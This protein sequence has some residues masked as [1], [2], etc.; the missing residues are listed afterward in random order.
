MDRSPRGRGPGAD[1]GE[2]WVG[3]DTEERTLGMEAGIDD[4]LSHHQRLLHRPGDRRPHPHLREGEPQAVCVGLD[5]E[6]R[7][8]P[9]PSDTEVVEPEDRDAG[10][11]HQV[12]RFGCLRTASGNRANSSRVAWRSRGCPATSGNPGHPGGSWMGLT[13]SGLGLRATA[14]A[15]SCVELAGTAPGGDPAPLRWSVHPT[16]ASPASCTCEGFVIARHRGACPSS[17]RTRGWPPSVP[18]SAESRSAEPD[19]PRRTRMWSSSTVSATVPCSP[20]A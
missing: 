6:G 14:A 8:A 11:A 5:P 7:G 12:P 2:P 19:R 18:P 16:T 20:R 4:Y 3:V 17:R 9:L 15:T 10:G 1:A 13:G